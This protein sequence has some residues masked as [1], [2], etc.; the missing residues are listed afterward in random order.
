MNTSLKIFCIKVRGRES[1]YFYVECKLQIII[2][3]KVFNLAEVL[4]YIWKKE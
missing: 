4:P 1:R 3:V 2:A